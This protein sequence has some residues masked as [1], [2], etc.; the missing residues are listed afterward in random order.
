M[1]FC[2]AKTLFH[3]VVICKDHSGQNLVWGHGVPFAALRPSLILR[4]G[5]RLPTAGRPI[6]GIA[7][8][9]SNALSPSPASACRRGELSN[10]ATPR[11]DALQVGSVRTSSSLPGFPGGVAFALIRIAFYF[12]IRRK[13]L[14]LAGTRSYG[15]DS[16]VGSGAQCATC[17][18]AAGLVHQ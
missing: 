12:S 6:G 4:C 3:G 15:N 5:P 7:K 10:D 17:R 1:T 9:Y 11:C 13:R 16:A 8:G 2:L 18:D 14:G